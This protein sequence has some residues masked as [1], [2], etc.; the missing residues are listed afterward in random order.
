MFWAA[1][2]PPE[3]S[4]LNY[5]ENGLYPCPWCARHYK[6]VS[7]NPMRK[8]TVKAR[9]KAKGFAGISKK[10][11]PTDYRYCHICDEAMVSKKHME[12]HLDG[13]M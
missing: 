4:L 7:I 13:L 8:E 9:K 5:P 1:Y 6:L 2:H 3:S 11:P 12:G 10:F